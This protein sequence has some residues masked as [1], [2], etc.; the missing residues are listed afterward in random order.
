MKAKRWIGF[1]LS[2]LTIFTVLGFWNVQRVSAADV[3]DKA[4]FENLK[5]TIASTGDES[6]GYHSEN[7]TTVALK[8]SGEFSFPNVTANEIKEGDFFIVEAPSNLSLEDRTLKLEDKI[9]GKT[10]GNV[11]V[12]SA[13]HRLVF[14]FNSEVEDKQNIRGDF[15]ASAKETVTKEDKI[16]TYVLPGGKTQII[17]F[18]TLKTQQAPVEGEVIYKGG[19]NHGSLA[20]AGYY[21]RINRSQQDLKN[22]TIEITD[23]ISLG[24]F[25]SY[26][27]GSFALN[28]A[29][30]DTT[31]TNFAN[32]K[33]KIKPYKVTTDPE[34]YKKDS[35]NTALLTLTNG[36]RSFK[37][38]MPTNMG[39]KSFFLEYA[40]TSP[41]DTSEIKNS[42][43]FLIDNEPQ[44]TWKKWGDKINTSKESVVTLKT[45][46]AAGASVTADI[47]GKIK[48][49]KFDEADATVKL[50][51]VVF[52]IREKT[53]NNL[54]DTVTTDADGIALSKALSDGKYIV[55]EKTP[56]SGY[57]VNSQEF[58]V[59]LKGGQGVPL[60]IPNKRETV[61]F[62]ATKTWV[63]G[64]KT[65]YKQV[66]LGLY[67]RK[68]GESIDK[69]QRV[70]GNYT[71]K[72][73]ESNG[74]YTYKWEKQ[75]PK[76]DVD[77]KT[78][79]VY[80]V[81][82][83]QDQTDL[84]LKEGEK[85]KV[86]ENNY[87][88][89]YNADKTQVTNTYEVP[90]INV[91]AKK[92]WVGGQERVRPTTYF[93]LYRTLEGGT[94]EAAPNAEL[95]KVPTTDGTVKWIGLPA[96]DQNAKKYTYSVKEV[97]DKGE[98]ITKVDGYTP[99]Q[100][101][102]LTIKNTYSASPAEAVIEAKKK[103]EGR[104]TELQDEE[105]E[106]ILKDNDG[107][108]VQRIKNK[109]TNADGTGR[110]VFNPIKFTKEGHYQYTIVEAK[111]GETENGITY[112]N[113][114]VPVIVHVYDNG[115][116]Q[117]VAWVEKFEISQVALPAADFSTSAPGSNL[118]PPISG[119]INTITDAGIQTFTNTYKATKVKVPVAATKSFINKNTDKPIQLQGGEFEFALFEKNGTDP[120]QTTTNDATG[121]IKFEDLEFNKADTYHYTIV[122]KNAG[123][124]DKGITYSN[125]TIEV[126]IKVVDN[127]KGA[128]EATV[129]YDNN[130]S[131]FENT[132][133]A[134]NAKAV[135]EV[136]K[137]L[138]NRNLEANMFEFTLT[139]Q[140]GNVEKAKNGA[141]GKVKFSELTFDE[142]GT[143]TYTIKEVKAGTTENG[144]TY[145]AKTVTAKV[146]VTDDGQGKLHAAVEYSSDGTANSTTF[147]NVY[148][149]A[150]DTSITLGAKKVLEGKA[151]EAGKYSFVLKKAD[152]TVV[153][154]VTNA[155]DG[156]VTFSPI[157]YNESQV[158]THKY[159][160]SE[161]A[162]SE[163]G[164]TYD[165]TVQEVEVTVEKV[166]ATELKATASKEAKDLVFTNKYT[167][168]G[169]TSITLGAKKV[170]EGKALEAG[171]YSFVLKKADGTV[172][173]T[174][175]NAADGTVTFSPI[176]YNESQVG[177]HKY[178]ISEVAGSEAGITYD[179]TVREVEVKVEKISATELKATVSKEAKDLV[180]TNKYTPAPATKVKIAGKKVLE[181]KTL[182]AGKYNFALKKTDGSVVQTVTNDVDGNFAFDE[183]TYDENQVG[184]HKYT[185]SEVA[186]SEAG[187]TY[188]KTV[189]EVE[190]KVEKISAT[191]LKAT[192][193]K[194]AKDLV[195]TNKYT[196]AKT[197]I[198]VKKV[199][200]DADNQDG[201]RPASITVKLLADGQDTGKTL[202]LSEAN[203]W[204]GNFT[205]L[206]ADKGG[207]PIDYKV[208][209]V[210]SVAG[211]TTEISGDAKTGFTITNKYTPETIDIKATK[212]WDD[213]N[214]QDGKRP[215]YITVNLLADGEKVASKEVKA[216]ADGTWSTVFT[217]LPKFKAGKV[218]KYSLT[219][220]VVS[221]YTSEINDFN[222]TNKYT[223]KMIDYQVTK[224]WNDNNN[225]DGK[226]PDHI[227]V[228]LMKT[229][230]GVTTEV[231]KYDIKVAEAD[232]ANG[233][234]WKHTFT[235]LPKYEAGQEIVYSVK[236]DAVAGYETSIKGQEITNTHEPETIVISGKKVWEDANNQD[237]K[238]TATVK[239][240]ILKGKEIVDEIETSEEKGWAFESK[241]LP[242]YENGQEIKYDV[243]EVAVESYEKPIVEKSQD[244]KYTITNK[245]T[246]EKVNLMGQKTWNDANNQDNIR[247]TEIK[248]RLLADDKDTGKMATAS[249]ATGWKYSFEGL[250]RY[251]DGKEIVYSVE[252]VDVP[253]G[254]QSKVNGMNLVNSHTPEV[255]SVSGQKTWE[256]EN[257]K[258]GLRPKE[259]QVKLLANGKDTGK[260]ATVSEATGWKYSFEKLAKYEAGKEITYTVEEVSVPEGYTA[261]VDGMNITNR[262]TPE[263]P[264][265]PQT[266][267]STPEKSKK[268]ILPSTGSQNS[269][270]A[271][272]AGL[273]TLSGAAYL[274]KKKA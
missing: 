225:Q 20:K 100:I 104:P 7:D 68:K 149:P 172:V 16:V 119:A 139:D 64:K 109:G 236:E 148:T 171:K 222:I 163:T 231:E 224:T 61:D 76:Y 32:L 244:G 165:K 128:L 135:L 179:K 105:F 154:T 145:D 35:D 238:R 82:E 91:T 223:P 250:D 167:P 158:G 240:Q 170:L 169:D 259:I 168:A 190:V 156:T 218:I 126:T 94:E 255:T 184:T 40:T 10:I 87:V 37:L 144:I 266:P 166:S 88:V 103:L 226:R 208:V 147:N 1:F 129:T 124:T 177:T 242:K 133:K 197:Q 123:T 39:K 263:K 90:K 21:V 220:E 114:T 183:L 246:P 213:A 200:D 22:K 186:G 229:V 254:Y 130:D 141:D 19:W 65:D 106:F 152:G 131:T 81:R 132:Y 79:L 34:E 235:N 41:A 232:P 70:T 191:E 252:E 26:I 120:I 161:V 6:T 80:S 101:D 122:E 77:G 187:I 181:G 28:E 107:K 12:E 214:N 272:L 146:T 29:E 97:D 195:F 3:T 43:Q 212:N 72:V 164:I 249:A 30:F 110:V 93:K 241:P 142:A 121:N 228:H 176:S 203:G 83:L 173:E 189:R 273:F 221:E 206:D 202:E 234:V 54:V 257:D 33:R 205:D 71:P 201:K 52:E 245:R 211:Y 66:K 89:S 157:S 55:K 14:T 23:D 13:K 47:A 46:K 96:T 48:I 44:L 260:V 95:K 198:P 196:P 215:K 274:L 253:K 188:D 258:D 36:K 25:A 49:T 115:R 247:P 182:E 111:A 58:E 45:V 136:D 264:Q 155:A 31:N 118:V 151:L 85:V 269:F 69:A 267:P 78:E 2:L 268:K 73:T 17:T 261:K 24:A 102:P 59:E 116:G 27:D 194:E 9:S 143:Y 57:Q 175:T 134:E 150:G 271:L 53:T 62:E 98:L 262:H 137:K 113:R 251:K 219:E 42:A 51:G 84:P 227:T 112:D 159:T 50:A 239:V 108:E 86:G 210:S 92:V 209:E 199:W 75:L 15:F 162:G 193:S 207:A 233:N 127:G 60:N 217:K 74:V 125:K 230:G 270:F 117:L 265:I 38:L 99:S 248:V 256:D 174:V 140:V 204:A 216:A 67:V 153:E 63:D 11:R 56:K 4:K 192:V 138:S 8:Y 237:G 243:K 185:I 5:I 160:I 180:F 178:T 18:K